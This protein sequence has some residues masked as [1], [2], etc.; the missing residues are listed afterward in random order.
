MDITD[1]ECWDSKYLSDLAEKSLT[2]CLA[3]IRAGGRG[4]DIE[5][6]E[7]SL[8]TVTICSSR[9]RVCCDCGVCVGNRR[10]DSGDGVT[11]VGEEIADGDGCCL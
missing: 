2:L 1:I 8:D 9:E 4:V 3:W 10:S 11:S 7:P 5:V 6:E